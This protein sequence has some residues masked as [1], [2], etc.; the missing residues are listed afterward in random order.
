[1]MQILCLHEDVMSHGKTAA[2]PAFGRDFEAFLNFLSVDD[3]PAIL[4]PH[5]FGLLLSMDVQTLAA[6]AQVHRNTITRAPEA[7]SVQRFLRD[8]VRVIRSGAD[9]GGTV[10]QS[11]FWFKNSPLP[12]FGYKTPQML[13]SERRADDLLRYL[14]SLEAGFA[15]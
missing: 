13:V 5:R 12:S 14:S 11:L 8:A 6:A 3:L 10:E 7:E 9:I 15:G 1:M 4:S 2:N